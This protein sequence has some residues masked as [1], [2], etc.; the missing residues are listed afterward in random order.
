MKTK[1]TKVL[2]TLVVTLISSRSL[3][4][5]LPNPGFTIDGVTA[6][7]ITDPQNDFL[8]PNGVT[9]GVVGESV[10]KNN[11]VDNL[12]SLFKL[13]EANRIKVFISPHYY[14]KHDHSWQFEGALETLMHN[15]NMFDRGDQ[16]NKEGFEG[17]GA[18]FLERYKKYIEKDFVT[19]V[20]PHKVY[21]PEQNDLSLQLRKQKIDK[22]ILAGMSGNLCVESHMRELLEDGFEVAVVGDATASAIIPGYDGN[23]AAQTNFRFI[24]SHVFTTN[25]LKNEFKN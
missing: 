17:S 20:G 13:A 12:E 10:T 23:A 16:L 24:A 4:A 22:V 19:V 9:W 14:Y 25:E 21:G 1:I 11:T 15:I 3:F 5:Q 18:D 6:I 8:S 7:V 2:L